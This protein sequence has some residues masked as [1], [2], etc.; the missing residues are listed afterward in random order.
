MLPPNHRYL[1]VKEALSG[2]VEIGDPRMAALAEIFSGRTC[3]RSD[4]AY[5]HDLYT[6]PEHRAVIDAFFLARTDV[7]TTSSLLEIPQDVLAAYG[8][9]F[10]DMQV[11]RNK[12]D[13]WSY[14]ASYNGSDYA[15]EIV[16]TAVQVGQPYLHWLYGATNQI[17]NRLVVRRT[18]E[19]A[20]FRGMAHKG[21]SLTSGMSKEALKWWGVSINNAVLLEKIDP[22]TTK[23]A[24]NELEIALEQRDET[25]TPEQAPVPLEEILH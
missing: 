7:Q 13:V 11:F 3:S 6:H 8:H 22:Q 1:A 2:G 24:V 18:M 19:D 14:A 12:L 4:V 15:K 9:L 20:F 10:L 25:L 5:A 21:N 23:S 17:D 16:R